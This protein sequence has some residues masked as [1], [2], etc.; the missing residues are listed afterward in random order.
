MGKNGKVCTFSFYPGQMGIW[1]NGR[2]VLDCFSTQEKKRYLFLRNVKADKKCRSKKMNGLN[3]YCYL[4][5][6][7]FYLFFHLLNVL[8]N[9]PKETPPSKDKN[10][11]FSTKTK[12]KTE[13]IYKNMFKNPHMNNFRQ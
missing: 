3:F 6:N 7:L 12:T 10:A 13:S 4:F 5:M 11:D 1:N 9:E 8:S 2:R